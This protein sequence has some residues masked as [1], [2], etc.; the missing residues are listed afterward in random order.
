MTQR[1]IDDKVYELKMYIADK[2]RDIQMQ[3]QALKNVEDETKTLQTCLKIS[4]FVT[5]IQRAY[6]SLEELAHEEPEEEP[7]DE[8]FDNEF[9]SYM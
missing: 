3:S 9:G 6:G 8:T 2:F 5:E 7:E 1:E 4:D